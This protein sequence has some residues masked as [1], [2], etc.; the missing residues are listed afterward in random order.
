VW[1]LRTAETAVLRHA[2]AMEHAPGRDGAHHTQW[3]LKLQCVETAETRVAPEPVLMPVTGTPGVNG[4]I[5]QEPGFVLQ[6]LPNWK[7]A[8]TVANGQEIAAQFVYGLVG[9]NAPTKAYVHRLRFKFKIA[10]IAVVNKGNV[11]RHAPG[12]NGMPAVAKAFVIP[13]R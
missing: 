13:V 9:P 3:R 5:V 6:A 11:T 1:R 4:V 10:G 8:E 12:M 2:H 7:P